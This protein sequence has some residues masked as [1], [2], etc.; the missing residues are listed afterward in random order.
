MGHGFRDV[1]EM[2]HANQVVHLVE[3]MIQKRLC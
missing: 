3:V 1:Q 2:R